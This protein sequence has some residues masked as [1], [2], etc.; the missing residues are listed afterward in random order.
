MLSLLH[1]FPTFAV[2]GAQIRLVTI[3]NHFG[4]A[5][6]HAVIAMD[7]NTACRERLRPELAVEFPAVDIRKGDTAGNVLRFR[8]VLTSRRPDVLVTHNW[9]SI[10]W[11]MANAL[12]AL[13]HV[14]IE[15]GF[16]PEERDRQIPRRVWIRRLF[17]RRASVVLPSRTLERIALDTWRLPSRQVRYLPNGVDLALFG[18]GADAAGA[19][20]WPAAGEG[21]VI[22]TV[23]ALRPEK[24]LARLLRAFA[25]LQ[26]PASLVIVGDGPER[27]ALEALARDLGVA[28][29]VRF[30]GQMA[31]PQHAYRHFDIFALSSDTEQMPLSLLEAMASGL[32]AAATDVGDVSV[33]LAAENR[34]FIVGRGEAALAGA[35]AALIDAPALRHAVGAANRAKAARDYDQDAMFHA[36][37]ALVSG[38]SPAG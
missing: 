7:G 32:P 4:P 14:H 16:G 8:R 15:D 20:P 25:R 23:A 27:P 3:A 24:N 26:P 31:E 12:V 28:A 33:M 6:R 17:L 19:P 1:V 9:G 21:P 36:Y 29:A 18:A 2:G 13:R 5:W 35:L 38:L 22:G 30:T 37:G 11:A 34:P 10:E